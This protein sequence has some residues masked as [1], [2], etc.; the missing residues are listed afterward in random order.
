MWE[1]YWVLPRVHVLDIGERLMFLREHKGQ[2]SIPVVFL[3]LISR[4][5]GSNPREHGEVHA[6]SCVATG[7][8]VANIHRS[9]VR[10]NIHSPN[11]ISLSGDLDGKA[12]KTAH[13]MDRKS[14]LFQ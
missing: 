4:L 14:M 6:A 3:H 9:G 2:N 8:H 11:K 10:G 5:E 1:G 13:S 7:D 12:T